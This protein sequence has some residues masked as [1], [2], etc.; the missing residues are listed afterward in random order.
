[1][2]KKMPIRVLLLDFGNVLYLADQMIAYRR[3]AEYSPFTAEEIHKLIY[4]DGVEKIPDEGGNFADFYEQSMIAIQADKNVLVPNL[5]HEIWCDIFS[6]VPGMAGLLAKVKPEVRIILV[7]NTNAVHWEGK[8]S[9]LLLIEKYFSDESNQV[10]SY[11]VGKRKPDNKMWI[12]ACRKSGCGPEE[13]LFVD[14]FTQFVK[15]FQNFGGNG[16]L[17]NA[18]NDSLKI[19]EEKLKKEKLI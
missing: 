12:A 4:L 14:D 13:S 1:M 17:F 10:L 6:P 15:S 11:K 7:S 16:F 5:F 2:T 8:M 3:F 9:K 19:L 18:K